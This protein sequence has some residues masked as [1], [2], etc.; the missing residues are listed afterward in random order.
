[1]T[2]RD[3]A[4][5]ISRVSSERDIT[6]EEDAALIQA[7]ITDSGGSTGSPS[8]SRGSSVPAGALSPV[9]DP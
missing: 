9:P 1:M 3:A 7:R 6:V 2:P 4:E 5:E 8:L